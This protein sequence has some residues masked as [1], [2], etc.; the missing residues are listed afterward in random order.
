LLQYYKNVPTCDRLS[1]NSPISMTSFSKVSMFALRRFCQS[2]ALQSSRPLSG[3]SPT[4]GMVCTRKG[5]QTR[6]AFQP[7]LKPWN[8]FADAGAPLLPTVRSF[9][10]RLWSIHVHLPFEYTYLRAISVQ[11]LPL[12]TSAILSK[13]TTD[14][15]RVLEYLH[16]VSRFVYV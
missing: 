7:N 12:A 1:K 2:P 5:L 6:A 3:D 11:A 15:Q 9:C 8:Q 10:P 14:W 4:S 16:E 13:W